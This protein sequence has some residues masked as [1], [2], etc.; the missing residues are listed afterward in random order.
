MCCLRKVTQIGKKDTDDECEENIQL[1]K[2]TLKVYV[3]FYRFTL[4]YISF[5]F[6][7]I[8]KKPHCDDPSG[9]FMK[10]RVKQAYQCLYSYFDRT[11][12][13]DKKAV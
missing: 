13:C 9:K 3:N 8:R 12:Q 1:T 2:K 7:K 4:S 6:C 5:T 10:K 11:N